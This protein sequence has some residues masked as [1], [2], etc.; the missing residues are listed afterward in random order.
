MTRARRKIPSEACFEAPVVL[1]LRRVVSRAAPGERRA[2]PRRRGDSLLTR[3]SA[4]VVRKWTEPRHPRRSVLRLSAR[5]RV[6]IVGSS[7][8]GGVGAG[9][10]RQFGLHLV[11]VSAHWTTGG[12]SVAEVEALVD[13]KL[14]DLDSFDAWLD[15]RVTLVAADLDSCVTSPPGAAPSGVVSVV[16]FWSS[17]CAD[18][19]RSRIGSR[20]RKNKNVCMCVCECVCVCVCVCLCV[21]VCT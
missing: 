6:I 19:V 12:K 11:N 10:R 16:F 9:W 13:A 5:R 21:C 18:G 4:S 14:G 1:T 17:S 7:I 15:F 8:V 3:K 20:V 2:A